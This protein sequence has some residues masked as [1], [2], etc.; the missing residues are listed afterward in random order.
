MVLKNDHIDSDRPIRIGIDPNQYD[1]LVQIGIWKYRIVVGVIF[2]ISAESIKIL[3]EL[4]K[5]LIK[6]SVESI[7][8]SIKS[9]F[10]MPVPMGSSE[11]SSRYSVNPQFQ[12]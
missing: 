9:I 5:I 2:K 10:G 11:S 6:I 3:V 7:K 4:N 8:I 1:K 12:G